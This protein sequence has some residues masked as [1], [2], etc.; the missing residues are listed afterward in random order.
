MGR[1]GENMVKRPAGAIALCC[2]CGVAIAGY[3]FEPIAALVPDEAR[4]RSM[5]IGDVSGDGRDDL[6]V[7]GGG[8]D[9]F[10][11]NK[12]IVY[13][14]TADGTLAP[15]VS[16]SYGNDGSLSQ[17]VKLA[18]LDGDGMQDIVISL[19]YET[20]LLQNEGDLLFTPRLL[21]DTHGPLDFD[22]MDVD[23]DGNLDIVCKFGLPT[24][25]EVYF[26]DGQGGIRERLLINTPGGTEMYL[27]DMN[28]DG[29]RDLGYWDSYELRVLFHLHDG[30]GFSSD[31]TVVPLWFAPYPGVGDVA[32][33][34]FNG[35]GRGDIA[36]SF[37]NGTIAL[38]EQSQR[39]FDRRRSVLRSPLSGWGL[40]AAD[41]D[42]NGQQDL[43]Q[44]P[45][46]SEHIGLVLGRPN[47]YAP[48]ILFYAGGELGPGD[49]TAIGDLNGDGMKDLAIVTG[50]SG[51]AYLRGRATP[52]EADLG[53]YLEL[54][55]TAVAVRVDNLTEFQD[56][57]LY[58]LKLALDARFGSLAVDAFPEGCF[59][60]VDER[61]DVSINCEMDRLAPG[62][63][64]TL[65]FPIT[66]PPR[67]TMNHLTASASI[68]TEFV[69]SRSD[70]N[71]A[72]KRI[73]IPPVGQP[74]A[75]R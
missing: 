53:V 16:I 51:I 65:N 30:V 27:V 70:N 74:G 9:P 72:R 45:A 47:G 32:L 22:F 59:E 35:D 57:Q 33:A 66:I 41:I 1:R 10:Y 21:L 5:A 4:A 52:L 19:E 58:E 60:N 12:V 14:Q 50:S 55:G 17:K 37:F 8:L 6:V 67:S 63:S 15:P 71:M 11:R 31:Y 25:N 75:T 56:S 48:Q 42:G 69:E 68:T 18:D 44:V 54:T 43:L 62:A 23:A 73:L 34:D 20:R 28:G 29:R 38:L 40:L 13:A 39:G 64:R 7:L 49:R 36:A 2:V 46:Y 3:G 61:H 26:G 24:H